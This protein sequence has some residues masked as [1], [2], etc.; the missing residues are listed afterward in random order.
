MNTN[1]EEI[2]DDIIPELSGIVSVETPI[3]TTLF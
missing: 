1:D 3:A 2:W